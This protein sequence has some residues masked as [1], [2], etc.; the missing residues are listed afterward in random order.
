MKKG[1]IKRDLNELQLKINVLQRYL[2]K[3]CHVI[4]MM[5][6]KKVPSVEI[7]VW[8]GKIAQWLEHWLLFQSIHVQFLALT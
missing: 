8:A 3:N 1:L 6:N 7:V 5:K 4:F 2:K